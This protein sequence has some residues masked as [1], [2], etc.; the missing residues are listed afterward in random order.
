MSQR[1]SQEISSRMGIGRFVDFW[2]QAGN[3][4]RGRQSQESQ[5]SNWTAGQNDIP[6]REQSCHKQQNG[7]MLEAECTGQA[8]E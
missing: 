3:H 4:R 2:K 6:E 1:W 7:K 8:A 5:V